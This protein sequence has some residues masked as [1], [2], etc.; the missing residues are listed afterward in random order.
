MGHGKE[1]VEKEKKDLAFLHESDA[2]SRGNAKADYG[3]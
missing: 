1:I 2:Q 3:Q